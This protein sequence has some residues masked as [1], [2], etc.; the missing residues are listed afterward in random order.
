M[1]GSSTSS[2]RS[3]ARCAP[4]PPAVIVSPAASCSSA[5]LRAGVLGSEATVVR[6]AAQCRAMFT[7]SRSS[8]QISEGSRW[9][10]RASEARENAVRSA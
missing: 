8:P 7:A 4:M 5:A 9:R 3:M 2:N 1:A 6:A 10:C